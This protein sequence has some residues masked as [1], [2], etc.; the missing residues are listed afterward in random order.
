MNS[1][2]PSSSFSNKKINSVLIFIDED[3]TINRNQFFA[4]ELEIS[5]SEVKTINCIKSIS[6]ELGSEIF[7]T[8]KDF[9]WLGKIKNEQ[10]QSITKYEFDLLINLTTDN[11]LSD[12]LIVLSKAKF[13]AGFSNA[14]KRLYDFMIDTDEV[15][16]FSKE[17]KKYLKILNKL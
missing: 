11:L 8:E 4:K 1:N 15:S 9:S 5:V 13:K 6:K 2:K 10:I 17:L 14:D 12:Y 7:L 3:T 16:V